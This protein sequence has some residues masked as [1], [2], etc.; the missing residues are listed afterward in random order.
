MRKGKEDWL[1]M[2]M[3]VL[4]TEGFSKITIDH[5]CNLLGVTKGSFYHH[6]GNMGG[7]T[8]ALM[9]YWTDNYTHAFINEVEK[10]EDA[11]QKKALL[12]EMTTVAMHK[13]EQYIRAW[14]FYNDT[15]KKYVRQVDDMRIQY[16]EKLGSEL[17]MNS[18]SAHYFA[19]TEYAMLVGVQQ[20]YPDLS[21]K[22][23]ADIMKYAK[24]EIE[25]NI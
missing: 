3:D 5:L 7:Y 4:N 1:R 17:G 16:L 6:F 11:V 9:Q 18:Q 13:S 8:E 10:I 25:R 24:L 19:M 21:R 2:G 14:S 20:L 15:V 12:Y 22:D 23:Y